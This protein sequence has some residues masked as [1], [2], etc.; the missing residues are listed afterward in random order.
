MLFMKSTAQAVAKNM[1]EKRTDAL[2]HECW[3]M[4]EELINPC[5]ST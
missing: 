3:N 5:T 1:L 4:G 2:K